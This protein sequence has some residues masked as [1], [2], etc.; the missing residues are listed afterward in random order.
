VVVDTK[1]LVLNK[2]D[3]VVEVVLHQ[4]LRLQEFNHNKITQV[5]HNGV[6]LVV[7]ADNP[8][9]LAAV[10][11]VLVVKVVIV[12]VQIMVDKVVMEEDSPKFLQHLVIMVFS[13]AAAV[14]AV[15]VIQVAMEVLDLAVVDKV[16]VMK[17][18]VLWM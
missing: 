17:A 9:G 18:R 11:V 16:V 12:L 2:E 13:V 14:A 6:I 5:G 4:I 3:V 10:A 15:M 1:H 7:T 8:N